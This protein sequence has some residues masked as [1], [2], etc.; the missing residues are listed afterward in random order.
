MGSTRSATP[1]ADVLSITVEMHESAT[2]VILDGPACEYTAPH[3]D[4][5][6]TAIEAAGRHRIVVD[7]DLVHT[8]STAALTVLADHAERCRVAGGDLAIRRPS[9][10]TRRVLDVL[11]LGDLLG[12]AEVLAPA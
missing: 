7:A 3:L 11:G 5:Q 9:A 10:V 8:M 1:A 12:A 2:I 4:T 6:L